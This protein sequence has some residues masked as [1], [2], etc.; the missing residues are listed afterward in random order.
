MANF[1]SGISNRILLIRLSSI[2]D[3]ILTTALVRMMSSQIH[4][5]KV[6]FLTSNPFT[7]ILKYN[8]HINRIIKYDKSLPL[9]EIANK[10]IKLHG[11]YDKVI[12]LQNNF[13]SRHFRL[14]LSD[15]IFTVKKNRMNKLSL[16]YLKKPFLDFARPVPEIYLETVKQL[17][18]EDDGKGL[19][20]WLAAEENQNEYP[21][22]FKKT[23]N[24]NSIAVAPGAHHF[25]KRWQAEKFLEL[26]EKLKVELNSDIFLIGGTADK[27][28]T[29]FILKNSSVEINDYSC[30]ESIL[31]TAEII[32]KC[33]LLI[34][35]DSG[36]M[37]IAAARQT[38]VIAIFGSTVSEFGFAPYRVKSKIIQ[39]DIPCRP[40]TH[41]GRSSCPKSHFKCMDLIS[42]KDVF[43]TVKEFLRP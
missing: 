30:S 37:H 27:E 26:I 12:D 21:P 23:S 8:P 15:K 4:G 19:E 14:G 29:D 36:V 17:G 20:L 2:G 42:V 10:K 11:T 31:K 28:T 9:K 38:P 33:G 35:S 39:K 25:T 7:E 43:T 6:D 32:D 5:S 22:G 34:S 24:N 41:I 1:K 40:C 16:V 13:R 3:I 18:I